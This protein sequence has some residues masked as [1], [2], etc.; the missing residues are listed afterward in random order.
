MAPDTVLPEAIDLPP[1][2]PI[3]LTPVVKWLL[4]ENM[5]QASRGAGL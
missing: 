5:R 3:D 2:K 4:A 1:T